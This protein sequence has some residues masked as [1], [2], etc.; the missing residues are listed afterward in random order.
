MRLTLDN[1]L[2]GVHQVCTSMLPHSRCWNDDRTEGPQSIFQKSKDQ[3]SVEER[4]SIPS[5]MGSG[6]EGW[7]IQESH[8]DIQIS[9]ARRHQSNLPRT[10]PLLVVTVGRFLNSGGVFVVF[11]C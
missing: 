9:S 6:I 1:A 2:Y 10:G 5:G 7:G 4:G 11:L 3:R 8:H